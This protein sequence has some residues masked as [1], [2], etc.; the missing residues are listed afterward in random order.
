TKDGRTVGV[1][2]V[3]RDVT[4]LRALHEKERQARRQAE[5]ANRSKDEFLAMLS[6]ELRTPLSSI[7][8]WVTILKSKEMS[9]D[10]ATHAVEVIERNAKVEAQLVESLLDLSRISSGKLKVSMEPLDLSSVVLAAVDSL[11]PTADTKGVNLEA[12][13]FPE[14]IRINGDSGR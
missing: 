6:H 13:P 14:P 2:M 12:R 7:L 4:V 8:G 5:E 3:F 10:R 11:R 1:V 9:P